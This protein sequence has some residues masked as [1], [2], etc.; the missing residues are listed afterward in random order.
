M[1]R[2][3]LGDRS[4]LFGGPRFVRGRMAK[5]VHCCGSFLVGGPCAH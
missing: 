3:R 4:R 2:I 1:T 5:S